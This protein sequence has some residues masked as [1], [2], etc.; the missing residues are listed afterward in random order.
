MVGKQH[1]L[2]LW[3]PK[4]MVALSISMSLYPSDTSHSSSLPRHILQTRKDSLRLKSFCGM[5]WVWELTH[6]TRSDS[7]CCYWHWKPI[8]HPYLDRP[9]RGLIGLRKQKYGSQYSLKS[10]LLLAV[11]YDFLRLEYLAMFHSTNLIDCSVKYW[12]D[13][14]SSQ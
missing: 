7:R 11:E 1:L 6:D 2:F 13:V 9:S 5:T 8:D 12:D 10:A 3:Y 14:K 4:R